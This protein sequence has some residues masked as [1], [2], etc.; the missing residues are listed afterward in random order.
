MVE[1]ETKKEQKTK[2]RSKLHISETIQY[3]N[4]IFQL[5]DK[6]YQTG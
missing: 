6:D 2:S 4:K 5:N 3:K 1:G